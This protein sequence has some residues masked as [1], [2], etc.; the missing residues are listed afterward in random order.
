MG[1]KDFDKDIDDDPSKGLMNMLKRIYEEGDDE[2][3]KTVSKA[4]FEAQNKK[5]VD[6]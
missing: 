2:T 4:W 1:T 5:E 3:K 6:F